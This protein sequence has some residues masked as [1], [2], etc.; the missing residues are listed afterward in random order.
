MNDRIEGLVLRISDY[1]DNDLMLQVL[2]KEHEILSLIGKSSKKMTSKQHFF[3]ACLYEFIIDY[4]DTKTI[5]SIHGSKLI[6]SF[7]DVNNTL[8]FSF[9]NIF[10]EMILKSRGLIEK[11]SYENTVFL[12]ERINDDNKYLLGSLFVSYML[13]LHGIKP[14]VDECV[15]CHGKKVVGISNSLGGFLC[16]EHIGSAVIRDVVT[17]KKIRL[18]VK[19][20]F[21]DYELI[22]NNNYNFNDFQI[23]IE[24]FETN[25]Y[26]ELK[27]YHF[28]KNLI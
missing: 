15:V 12:L 6:K 28:Y 9:K 21:K 8:L 22:K 25:S 27:T 1:K 23:L 20:H 16:L 7:Y 3:E 26:I 18:I 4:K 11:N 17:L 14:N 24:F 10:F 13:E 19:A 5:Y 2:T